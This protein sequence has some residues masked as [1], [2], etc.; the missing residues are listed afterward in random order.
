MFSAAAAKISRPPR[1]EPVTVT[2]WV[3]GWRTRA[4][5]TTLPAPVTTLTTP[6]G[7][8]ASSMIPASASAASGVSSCGLRT[9]ALP[10]M[11]A[12]ATFLAKS[13]AG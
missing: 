11:I 2:I 10:D 12:G 7:T 5:P 6:G 1:T 8:P 13:A 9:M 4:S 3:M